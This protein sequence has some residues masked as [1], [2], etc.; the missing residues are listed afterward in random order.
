MAPI[1]IFKSNRVHQREGEAV[2]EYKSKKAK[3]EREIESS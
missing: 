3:K 2:P 1:S